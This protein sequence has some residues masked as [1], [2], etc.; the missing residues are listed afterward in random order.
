MKPIIPAQK[1]HDLWCQLE[2]L[3][4]E[5]SLTDKPEFC[6]RSN[7]I[8]DDALQTGIDLAQKAMKTN[9]LIFQLEGIDCATFLLFD[10][11][12]ELEKAIQSEIDSVNITDDE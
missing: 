5:F 7:M 6:L 12:E 1:V 4:L 11:V 10:S 3:E 2:K 9:K 8:L